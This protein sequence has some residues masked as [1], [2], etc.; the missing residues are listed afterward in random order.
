M[1]KTHGWQIRYTH[2]PTKTTYTV[3]D[4]RTGRPFPTLHAAESAARIMDENSEH[5]TDICIVQ[6]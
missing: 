2:P 6:V 1:E 5:A 3:S 4:W